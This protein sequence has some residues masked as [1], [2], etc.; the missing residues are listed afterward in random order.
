MSRGGRIFFPHSLTAYA[1]GSNRLEGIAMIWIHAAALAAAPSPPLPSPSCSMGLPS[2]NQRTRI[3]AVSA[4]DGSAFRLSH[5]D[6]TIRHALHGHDI[7]RTFQTAV[8][9]AA[10]A[11]QRR[12]QE[13]IRPSGGTGNLFAQRDGGLHRIIGQYYRPACNHIVRTGLHRRGCIRPLSPHAR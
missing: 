13:I 11:A 2:P 7:P 4:D 6:Q 5:A 1:R 8:A 12:T 9:A 3:S 10:T